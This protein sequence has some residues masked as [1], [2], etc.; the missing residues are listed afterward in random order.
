MLIQYEICINFFSSIADDHS[1]VLLT[2]ASNVSTSDY[3][4]ASSIVSVIFLFEFYGLRYYTFI[5]IKSKYTKQSFILN[6]LRG[7]KKGVIFPEF[8]AIIFQATV[9]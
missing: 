1:R 7:Q 4:N 3:I 6:A 2:E 8:Y 9:L 5:L